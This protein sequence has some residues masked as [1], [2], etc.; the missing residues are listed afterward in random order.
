LGEYFAAELNVQKALEYDTTNADIYGQLGI[1]FFRS[2]N[3][4][5][6]VFSLKC[7]TYGCSGEDSCKGRGLERCFE[8]VDEDLS[9]L[10]VEIQRLGLSPNT[11]VYY[12][13]YGSVLAA[14]S[15]PRDNNCGEAMQVLGDVRSELAAN[16]EAY[17]DGYQTI[18]S[19]VEAG[20]AICDSLAEDGVP[21][22]AGPGETGDLMTATPSP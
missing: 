5:G 4:E 21:L 19:I 18:L 17:A 22:S 20:E 2:R 9:E 13:T 15:R 12:Y 6:S 1:V 11:V 8:D 3:Y 14:L 7:A 10:P 16:P